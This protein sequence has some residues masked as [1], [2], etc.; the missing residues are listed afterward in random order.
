MWL[1]AN[2]RMITRL[3]RSQSAGVGS[4]HGHKKTAHIMHVPEENKRKIHSTPTKTCI[5][6]LW[7]FQLCP[8]NSSSASSFSQ[9]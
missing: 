1:P 5:A 9:R 3:H 2:V 4:M 8:R 6:S 7:V